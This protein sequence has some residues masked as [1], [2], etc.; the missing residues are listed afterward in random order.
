MGLLCWFDGEDEDFCNLRFFRIG[1]FFFL[2]F[3][4]LHGG[5]ILVQWLRECGLMVEMCDFVVTRDGDFGSSWWREACD[6]DELMVRGF[7]S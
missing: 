5:A 4:G 3:E 1:D 6:E 2:G 7:F